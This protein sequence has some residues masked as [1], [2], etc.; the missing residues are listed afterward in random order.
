LKDSS[1]LD[2]CS[3]LVDSLNKQND[4]LR[5]K[6]KV[7]EEEKLAMDSLQAEIIERRKREEGRVGK[8][9]VSL[10]W[11]TTDDLD[12]A[13]ED[14]QGQNL[15]YKSE[16][17]SYGELDIDQNRGAENEPLTQYPIENIILDNPIPGRYYVKVNF[18]TK[19]SNLS[20][21]PYYLEVNIG[22]KVYKLEQS[23]YQ[24]SKQEVE[25]W[26]IVYQFNYPQANN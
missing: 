5:K 8:V 15:W 16:N 21:I 7:V 14:P 4:D 24:A 1:A 20:E 26:Q 12:L 2:D 18:Y 22:G 19:R 13:I 9:T 3:K 10:I 6:L 11:N 25:D 23:V 17:Y